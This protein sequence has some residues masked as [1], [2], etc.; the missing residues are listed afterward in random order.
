MPRAGARSLG[1]SA[2]EPGAGVSA[3]WAV[4]GTALL[5]AVGG[6]FERLGRSGGAAVTALAW[7]V[8]TIKLC[9]VTLPLGT[10]ARPCD[11]ALVLLSWLEGI[12]LS[13]YG[14]VLTAVGLLVQ[15]GVVEP[16][17]GADQRALA[18]HA[19]LWDPWFLVW[20]LLVLAALCLIR[21]PL[22]PSG[23]FRAMPMSRFSGPLRTSSK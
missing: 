16:S 6:T 9:A 23:T 21:R 17:P 7:L 2:S 20:G 10:L 1:I 14:L 19:H 12:I 5:G 3:Y 4:G 18:W 8:V 15:G 13:G 11:R 22:G